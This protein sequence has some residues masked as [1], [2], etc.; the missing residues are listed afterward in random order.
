M[1]TRP[2]LLF[3]DY[4]GLLAIVLGKI[5]P[6]SAGLSIGGHGAGLKDGKGNADRRPTATHLSAACSAAGAAETHDPGSSDATATAGCSSAV[7]SNS[8]TT[9]E[10]D[11][12]ATA[13]GLTLSAATCAKARAAQGRTRPVTAAP[14]GG[15]PHM[16]FAFT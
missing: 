16:C 15:S 11:A 4:H 12:L 2:P 7:W 9:P 1:H 3:R 5:N 8:N 13:K 14:S 10:A 6:G